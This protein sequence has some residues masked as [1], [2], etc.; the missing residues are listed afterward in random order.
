MQMFPSSI[1][2]CIVV[3]ATKYSGGIC[4]SHFPVFDY[5]YNNETEEVIQFDTAVNEDC[6]PWFG[7]CLYS[8]LPYD[9]CLPSKLCHT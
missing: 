1:I 3:K 2:H 9:I 4:L 5:E 7:N 8:T 6:L